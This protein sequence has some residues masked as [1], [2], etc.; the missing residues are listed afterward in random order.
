MTPQPNTPRLRFQLIAATVARLI[1]ST[2]QRMFYPF[3][4]EF[5]R[6]LGVSPETITGMI[7]LRGAY[8]MSAP[9]FGPIVDR[10][11]RRNAM[12]I[13]VA[14][15][16]GGLILVAVYPSILTVFLCLMLIVTSKF[17]F[18]PALQAYLGDH[19]P[20]ERRGLYIALTEFGWAGAVLIGVPVVG[21][22]IARGDW[23]SPFLPLAGLGAL[24][25][26][27][28][29]ALIPPDPIRVDHSQVNGLD[30]WLKVIRNPSVLAVAIID[31]LLSGSNEI[32]SVVY[33]RWMEGAF[34]L[35]V[36]QLGLSVTV[37]GIAE[38]IAEAGVALLSDRLG[39]R[40]TLLLGM[41]VCA[42][43]YFLLPFAS[44]NITWALTGIFSVYLAFEFA[45]VAAIPLMSELMPEY[46]NTVMST[47]IAAHAAG[48]MMGS[49]AGAVVFR[50]GFTWNGIVAGVLTVI[51]IPLIVWVVKE[52][53]PQTSEISQISEV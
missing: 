38:L 33:G 31:L 10:F 4:P 28:M 47:G 25:L 30:R 50:F 29:A 44:P 6:G 13:G 46:R 3:L 41:V 36:E 12:L 7:S 52:R 19:I 20:Y 5:S 48:R 2:A 18:D 21:F 51:G 15:F 49:L 32:I 35:S 26:V 24:A 1:I 22:L 23:R 9:L 45:I 34:Q 27:G 43:C 17:V 39:K 37:I 42:V 11:G 16:C 8:G 53:H 14:I 40:Q